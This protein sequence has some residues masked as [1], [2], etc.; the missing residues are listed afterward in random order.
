MTYVIELLKNDGARFYPLIEI[1]RLL[2]LANF[3]LMSLNTLKQLFKDN[4]SAIIPI[5]KIER[6]I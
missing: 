1:S 2:A 4:T 6:E 3:E 5:D